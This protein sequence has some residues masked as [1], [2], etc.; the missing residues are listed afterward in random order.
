MKFR[1]AKLSEEAGKQ[2]AGDNEIERICHSDWYEVKSLGCFD[3][4]FP[5]D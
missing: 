4:H 1:I 5:N 2:N 3:L